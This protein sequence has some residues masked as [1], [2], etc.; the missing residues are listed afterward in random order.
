MGFFSSLWGGNVSDA[1]KQARNAGLQYADETLFKPYTVTTGSGT[2]TYD[3]ETNT[4]TTGVSEPY[5]NVQTS[6]LTGAQNVLGQLQGFDIGQRQQDIYGQQAALLQPQFQQQLQ[7]V[8]GSAFGAGRLGL[9]IAGEAVGAGRGAQVQ[10]DVYGLGVAQNQMLG[11][12]AVESR[13]QATEEGKALADISTSL[14]NQGLSISELENT[15]MKLGVD[16]QSAKSA[17]AAAAGEIAMAGY[18]AN[19]KAKTASDEASGNLIGNIFGG[20]N[21]KLGLGF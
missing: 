4:W 6:A 16:A 10:P 18:G 1:G 21:T 2:A 19:V 5:Q 11:Q 13:R 14:L 9:K 15:L 17:A 3:P 20:L 7:D 8:Q 12:L